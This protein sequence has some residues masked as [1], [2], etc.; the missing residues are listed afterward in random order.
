MPLHTERGFS[1]FYRLD[2][3]PDR[4]VLIFSHSLGLDHGMW[5][6]QAVDL[7]PYFQVLRYDTRGHGASSVAPG[8]YSIAELGQDVLALADALRARV[9][10]GDLVLTIGAGDITK[11][12]TEL[13]ERLGRA[14]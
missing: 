9:T 4:P 3:A 8:D 13:L 12:G 14:P 11:T 10:D 5:D 2:G 6:A 1:S 7:L